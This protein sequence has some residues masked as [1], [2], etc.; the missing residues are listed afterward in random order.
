MVYH[1]SW[2]DY[3][4]MASFTE[5]LNGCMNITVTVNVIGDNLHGDEFLSLRDMIKKELMRLN[6]RVGNVISQVLD[7]EEYYND[8]DDPFDYEVGCRH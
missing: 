8:E 2:N 1:E 6:H 3:N 4:Y 5:E 7:G